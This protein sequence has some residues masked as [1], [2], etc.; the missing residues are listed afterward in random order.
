MTLIQ[1][2]FSKPLLYSRHCAGPG[3]MCPQIHAFPPLLYYVSQ[4]ADF[5]NLLFPGSSV[6]WLLAGFGRWWEIWGQEGASQGISPTP[7]SFR[8]CL[9]QQLRL[10]RG[11]LYQHY[12]TFG[13]MRIG[14][15]NVDEAVP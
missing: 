10:P 1:Q 12:H 5:C 15:N 6:S 8:W 11:S 7:I 3:P 2:M 13:V 4:G 9:L 14:F